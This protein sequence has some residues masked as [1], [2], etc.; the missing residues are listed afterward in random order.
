MS[1]QGGC[2]YN[3]RKGK[4]YVGGKWEKCPECSGKRDREAKGAVGED[5]RKIAEK[6]NLKEQAT[7]LLFESSYGFTVYSLFDIKPETVKPIANALETL[8]KQASVGEVPFDSY[9]INAGWRADMDKFLYPYCMRLWKSGVNVLPLI[10]SVELLKL[11]EKS[12]YF[13]SA[14]YKFEDY[15]KGDMVVLTM[16]QAT[17][18]QEIYA[19]CELFEH[20]KRN[21]LSTIAISSTVN[22]EVKKLAVW[23]REGERKTVFHKIEYIKHSEE[24]EETKQVNITENNSEN[25][26]KP[27]IF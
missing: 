18:K 20:R 16:L 3:C 4:I 14:G 26:K 19:I 12:E 10:D 6:L 5:G 23:A 15:C 11:R 2:S 8:I 24:A 9:V 25:S 7:G 21:N 17:T 27:L 13:T 1:I 22:R